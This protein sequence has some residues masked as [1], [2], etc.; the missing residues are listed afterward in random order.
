MTKP[1]SFTECRESDDVVATHT[2][3]GNEGQGYNPND[4]MPPIVWTKSYQIPNGET[5]QSVTSTIGASTDMLDEEV[6]RLFV[7]AVYYLLEMEV[8]EKAVVDLVGQYSPTPFGFHDDE[9]W[10]QKNLKVE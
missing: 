4:P 7:N 6:R 9:Y 3:Q 5:G 1:A 10:V 2:P 8:P